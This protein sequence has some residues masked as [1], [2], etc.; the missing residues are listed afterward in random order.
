[1]RRNILAMA[2]VMILLIHS[3]Y[4]IYGATDTSVLSEPISGVYTARTTGNA[5]INNLRFTDLATSHW[6]KEPITR[7]GAIEVIKGDSNGRYRPNAAVSKEE[8]LALLIRMVGK[9]GEAILAAEQLAAGNATEEALKTTWSK[10]YMKVA[11]SMGL[12]TAAEYRDSIADDQTSLDPTLSFMRQNA[13]TREQIAKWIVE[14]VSTIKPDQLTP[15]YTQQAIFNYTDWNNMGAEFTPYIEA[16]TKNKIMVGNGGRFQPKSSLTRAEFAQILKNMDKTLY[17]SMTIDQKGGF[18]AAIIDSNVIDPITGTATRSFL[19]RNNEGKVDQL[20]YEYK[21]NAGN[22]IAT[23][24]TPVYQAGAVNSMLSL[25]EGEAVEYLVDQET[26]ELLYVYSKGDTKPVKV[27]G[28]LQPITGL[29]QGQITIKT[30]DG[31]LFTYPMRASLYDSVGKTVR[32]D[33]KTYTSDTAPVSASVILTLLNSIVTDINYIGTETVYSEVSGIVKDNNPAFSYITIIDWNGKEIT[34]SYNKGK[35]VVEKQNYYDESDE[36]GYIDQ[37]FPD[38][39]FDDRDSNVEEIEVGDIV[40]LKID[41]TNKDY[42]SAIS[43]KT[44]YVVKYG[45]VKDIAYKGAEGANIII[46][47]DDLSVATYEISSGIPVLKSGKNVGLLNLLPGDVVRML[48]NQAVLEPGN[49]K[50]TVKELIIDQYGNQVANVYKGQMSTINKQQRKVTLNNSYSLTALGWGNYAPAKAFD[51]SAADVEYFQGGKQISLEYAE[52]YLTQAGIEAYVVT[53]EYPG[54]E[55]VEK[56]TFREGRDSV[57]S[58]SNVTY[59]NGLDKLTILSESNTIAM[60]PGTIVIKNGKLVQAGNVI[61]PD[62]AQ[63]ILNGNSSAAIVNIEPEPNNDAISVFRG[64]IQ[65]I[66]EGESFQ[67]QSHAVLMDVKWIYSPIPR[68]YNLTSSTL[69]Y[70]ED[71]IIPFDEFVD[72]SDIS[73]ADEVYTIIAEGTNASYLVKN[74]YATEGVKGQVYEVNESSIMIKD[75]SVYSSATNKWTILSLSNNYAQM[76]TFT[77]SVIIK[78]NKVITKDELKLGDNIRIMTTEDLASKL[79]L[80]SKRDVDAYIIFVE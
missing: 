3:V 62:Y 59:S 21:K 7:L 27:T 77:N 46:G 34:K 61:A 80:N 60:D 45:T 38:F 17:D 74:P 8:A 16:V 25:K 22:Q 20:N 29:D 36:I 53:S 69:I 15:V 41:P 73:K 51:I 37:M 5:I 70:D 44:N 43:A 42:V 56:I 40:H 14:A 32:I 23:K 64:R 78:N 49:V 1:M 39:R 28:I 31:V 11:N 68:I 9:E 26:K 67:V 76:N 13:V 33:G 35:V 66:K 75:A 79:L 58:P 24:D 55:K 54:T 71:G 6:A 18:V 47:Y 12:I 19:I 57:L 10:G 50:E 52:K 72:Y 4:M 30:K 63:V 48:I 2:M 65:S